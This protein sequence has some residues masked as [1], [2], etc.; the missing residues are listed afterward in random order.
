[1]PSRRLGKR[2]I[3]GVIKI[4]KAISLV[5]H[6]FPQSTASEAAL[7][8]FARWDLDVVHGVA[9]P[10]SVFFDSFLLLSPGHSVKFV[11]V[12]REKFFDSIQVKL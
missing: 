10:L 2:T 1:M 6:S 7:V 12:G 3:K 11:I 5:Y 8:A 9:K 4:E